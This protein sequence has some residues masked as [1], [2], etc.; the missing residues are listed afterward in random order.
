[1]LSGAFHLLLRDDLE[2]IRTLGYG[3]RGTGL[4]SSEAVPTKPI[5]E[6]LDVKIDE[7]ARML[8]FRAAH[9]SRH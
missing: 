3:Y 1:M 8:P 7:F 5:L 9:G 6:L 2:C 4:P